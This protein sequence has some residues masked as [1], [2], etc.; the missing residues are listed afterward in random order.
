MRT[1]EYPVKVYHLFTTNEDCYE[2]YAMDVE[3]AFTTL[4]EKEPTIKFNDIVSAI[5]YKCPSPKDAI[6]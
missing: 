5:E 3:D 2:V 6:N 4:L 1:F